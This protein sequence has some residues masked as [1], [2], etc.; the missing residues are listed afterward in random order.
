MPVSLIENCRDS[1]FLVSERAK[2]R[3]R[4]DGLIVVL[5]GYIRV[6]AL[7]RRLHPF[8]FRFHRRPE[9]GCL[10]EVGIDCKALLC[11]LLANRKMRISGRMIAE[12]LTVRLEFG[13]NL[14]GNEHQFGMYGV[15]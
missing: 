8:G 3:N 7:Y 13:P 11:Q 9:R 12:S 1:R 6:P 15:P 10:V 5:G 14:V 2:V 4:G